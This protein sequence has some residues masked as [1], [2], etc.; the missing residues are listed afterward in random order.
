MDVAFRDSAAT[1]GLQVADVVANS[2]F[3]MLAGTGSTGELLAPLVEAGRL[4]IM[5]LRLRDARPG[6]MTEP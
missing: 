1:A 6:W 5:P 3:Q 4:R 2:A